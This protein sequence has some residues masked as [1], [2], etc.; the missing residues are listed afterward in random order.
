MLRLL[1]WGM[2]PICTASQPCLKWRE[3]YGKLEEEGDVGR[4]PAGPRMES[5][6]N[7]LPEA[8][9]DWAEGVQAPPA[10]WGLQRGRSS[11]ED[12][13]PPTSGRGL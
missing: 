5:P 13:R 4:R 6:M 8:W 2:A 11:R 3:G 7:G 10:S 1:F 12:K 9:P